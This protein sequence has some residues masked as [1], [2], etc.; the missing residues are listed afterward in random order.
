VPVSEAEPGMPL[1]SVDEAAEPVA[2][3]QQ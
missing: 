3:E 2:E 1:E